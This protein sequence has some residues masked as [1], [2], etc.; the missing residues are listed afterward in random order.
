MFYGFTQLILGI[1]TLGRVGGGIAYFGHLGGMIAGFLLI[2][3]FG[4]GRKKI[5]YFWEW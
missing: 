4:Y 3:F 5:K 2:R 1:A